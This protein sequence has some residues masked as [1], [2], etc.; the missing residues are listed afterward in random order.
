MMRHGAGSILGRIVAVIAGLLVVGI[1]L[2]LLGGVLQ[3][4]LPGWLFDMLNLGWGLV[5]GIV[6][7]ALG[8]LVAIGMVGAL[9]WVFVGRRR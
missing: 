6:G 8:P 2:R 7:P 4:V 9:V 3:P 1:V 5:L